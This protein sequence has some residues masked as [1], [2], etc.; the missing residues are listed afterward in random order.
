MQLRNF[1]GLI[2][3]D[4]LCAGNV[5]GMFQPYLPAGCQTEPFSG[6]ILAEI[7]FFNIQFARKRHLAGAHIRIFRIVFS[8]Q[9]LHLIIRVIVYDNL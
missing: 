9:F 1:V 5:I 2:V 3:F 8:I 7:I 6:R 4:H